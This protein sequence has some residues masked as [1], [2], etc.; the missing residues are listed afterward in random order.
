MVTYHAMQRAIQRINNDSRK[1]NK[2]D[3]LKKIMTKDVYK[4][5]FAYSINTFN[6]FRYV[7]KYDKTYKYVIDKLN[8]KIITV[9]EVDFDEEL[10]KGFKISFVR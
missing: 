1:K 5:Y 10:K 2:K 9:Y 8:K 3:N 4:R 7:Q 6:I